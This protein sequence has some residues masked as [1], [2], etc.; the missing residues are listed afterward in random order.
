MPPH[1]KAEIG[2]Q[3]P[4]LSWQAEATPQKMTDW[5]R[6]WEEAQTTPVKEEDVDL[7]CPP[8]LKPYIKQ[9]MGESKSTLAGTK[10]RDAHLPLSMPSLPSPLLPPE[11]PEPSPLNTFWLDSGVLGMFKCHLGGRSWQI[12]SHVDHQE[13]T[14]KVCAS[15]EVPNVCN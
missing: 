5:S 13:F 12:S 10:M 9:L 8:Q 7:K 15:F 6:L 3:L 2:Y 11:D 1:T 14:N 4:P